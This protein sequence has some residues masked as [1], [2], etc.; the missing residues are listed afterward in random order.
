MDVNQRLVQIAEG[1]YVEQDVLNIVEKI[2]NYD[3]NLN[4]KYCDPAR[5]EFT[6]APYKIVELCPDGMERVVF[7]CWELNETIL[8]RIYAADNARNNV[9]TNLDNVNLIAKKTQERRYQEKR[10]E[11]QDLVTSYL[12]SPKGRYSF[13]REDG[14]LVTIDDQPG[15]EHKV[16]ES[17]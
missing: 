14:S 3:P 8:E 9:L 15:R 2:R 4:V 5:S 17:R 1:I 13:K 10:L 11:E 12:K 16:R 7:D 6:D